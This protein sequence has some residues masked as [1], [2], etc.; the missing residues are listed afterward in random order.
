MFQLN[1][2]KVAVIKLLH[3]KYLSQLIFVN[4]II[5]DTIQNKGFSY[6]SEVG[7]RGLLNLGKNILIIKMQKFDTV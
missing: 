7:A 6:L 3:T 4:M 5:I 1:D 2:N